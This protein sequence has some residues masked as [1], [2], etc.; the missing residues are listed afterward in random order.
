MLTLDDDILL[1]IGV[2]RGDVIWASK[3]PKNKNAAQELSL[4]A[5]AKRR[6]ERIK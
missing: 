6:S 4:V 2:T 5:K 1:D 3:L